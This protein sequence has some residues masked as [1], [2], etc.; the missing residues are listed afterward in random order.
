[1]TWFP[2]PAFLAWKKP[3]KHGLIE[4][5]ERLHVLDVLGLLAETER[6]TLP[7][8]R[9]WTYPGVLLVRD[10]RGALDPYW[11]LRC[12]CGRRVGALYRPAGEPDWKC[13]TC[14]SLIYASHRHPN[15]QHPSRARLPYRTKR[16][17]QR[18]ARRH[19][20]A[21]ERHR[22]TGA[23]EAAQV[24]RDP[25]P[26]PAKAPHTVELDCGSERALSPHARD[27]LAKAQ[28]VID[29][30]AE[31]NRR[32]LADSAARADDPEAP[33][34]LRRL[35]R[36][37]ARILASQA[38]CA[39]DADMSR[40]T[41]L[42]PRPQPLTDAELVRRLSPEQV[43]RLEA[44]ARLDRGDAASARRPHADASDDTEQG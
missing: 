6:R 35:A 28:A 36:K 5:A 7:A 38:S 16:R 31:T 29:D 18:E 30:D 13:R 20:H 40:R 25:P 4:E 24:H 19:Q 14:A 32:W 11:H 44:T 27:V 34:A 42:P 26:L 2:S 9:L 3:R 15:P 22:P 10:R 33:A 41:L 37:A 23:K 17:R 12:T 1:M 8:W 43:A 39:A 21:A